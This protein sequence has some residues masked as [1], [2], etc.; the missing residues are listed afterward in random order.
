MTLKAEFICSAMTIAECPSWTR[1]EIAFA[2]RSNVGKSS[3]LNALTG[4]K[5]LARTSKTPGRTRSLN[6]FRVGEGLALVDLPGHGYAKMSHSE[7]VKMGRLIEGYLSQRR[8]LRSLVLLIDA[9]R[10]AQT[11]EFAIAQLLRDRPPSLRPS[12]GLIVVG[13]KCDKLKRAERA[14]ALRRLQ[15][16]GRSP[17]ILCSILSGEGIDQL[18]RLLTNII[19]VDKSDSHVRRQ[20]AGSRSGDAER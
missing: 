3:L 2:G 5:G 9:R 18:R 16:L 8:E 12:P 7:A 19:D 10:D 14:A 1:A 4:R 17:V 13:T 20:A 11:E 6:F 15:A